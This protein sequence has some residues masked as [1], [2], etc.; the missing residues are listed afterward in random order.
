MK[1]AF[2]AH[3]KKAGYSTA[4]LLAV[5]AAVLWSPTFVAFRYLEQLG[6]ENMIVQSL[7]FVSAGAAM[8]MWM[9]VTGRSGQLKAFYREPGRF[10]LLGL[11][12]AFGMAA[13][14]TFS[15]KYTS[16]T[17]AQMIMNSNSILI[18]LFALF[19]GERLSLLRSTGILI[20]LA[21][22]VLIALRPV[23]SDAPYHYNHALGCF[24]AFASAAC[25]ALY[26]VAGK[27][28]VRRYG[29]AVC[30]TL[31][32][33]TGAVAFILMLPL[34]GVKNNGLWLQYLLLGCGLGVINTAAGNLCWY[35]AL[36]RLP[37]TVLGPFQYLTLVIGILWAFLILTERPTP[38]ALAGAVLI[39]VGVYVATKNDRKRPAASD[40]NQDGLNA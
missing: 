2:P 16:A 20:G 7:R 3:E 30:V 12:G 28:V 6:A 34:F 39:C 19:V 18:A 38:G 24:L 33:C 22:C 26:T 17:N 25:W 40:S 11:T 29:G 35:K 1:T 37:A 8:L 5:L 21:G 9:C 4:L 32:V 14:Q 36:E 15:V 13:A 23:K 10:I 27:G 31:S